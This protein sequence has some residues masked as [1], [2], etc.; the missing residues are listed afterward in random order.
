[1]AWLKRVPRAIADGLTGGR[2]GKAG[3]CQPTNSSSQADDCVM[4]QMWCGVD[5]ARL[6]AVGDGTTPPL[7]GVA[8]D[9]HGLLTDL[10]GRDGMEHLQW[11]V[12][13]AMIWSA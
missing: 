4:K 5:A 7:D 13:I 11:R 6:D 1:M 8:D 2:S 12:A 10:T 9:M 3:F